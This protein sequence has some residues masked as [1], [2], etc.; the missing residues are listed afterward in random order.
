MKTGRQ[1]FEDVLA[2]IDNSVTIKTIVNASASEI[3]FTVCSNKWLRN[4]LLFKDKDGNEWQVASFDYDLHQITT[5]V[6]SVGLTLKSGTQ[7]FIQ[8]PV[9]KS[10]TPLNL[11]N[12]MNLEERSGVIPVTPIVWLLETIKG[13][14]FTRNS[15][16]VK[17]FDFTFYALEYSNVVDWLNLD[18]HNNGVV[19][20]TAL[21]D[22]VIEAFERNP[23]TKVDEGYSI[24]EFNIFGREKEDGFISYL[25]SK[26][27]SGVEY[28]PRISA[29]RE[30]CTC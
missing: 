5:L 2:T 3:I 4:G 25:L 23:K 20:M 27:L 18:R 16:T 17:E 1:I 8:M 22:S 12:E 6:P 19:P 21:A 30:G 14:G 26:N 15:V 10:G 7:I 24:R 29:T 13:R 11:E 28:K 9:F